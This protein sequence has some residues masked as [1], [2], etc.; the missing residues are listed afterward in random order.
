[1]PKSLESGF[2]ESED[3]QPFAGTL[4]GGLRGFDQHMLQTQGI[5]ADREGGIFPLENQ[6]S[7]E[8]YGCDEALGHNG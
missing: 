1:M 5:V 4:A 6:R 7:I 2:G 3:N 8:E